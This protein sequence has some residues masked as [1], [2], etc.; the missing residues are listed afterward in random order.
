MFPVTHVNTL[1]KP[2]SNNIIS[3]TYL[4]VF[5]ISP[6]GINLGK[7]ITRVFP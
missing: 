3:S 4:Y 5:S 2:P 6:V 7:D 1:R